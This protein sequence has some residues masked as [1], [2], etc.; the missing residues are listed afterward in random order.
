M[1]TV[2]MLGSLVG[3]A[4]VITWRVR[5]GQTPVTARK[6]LL[7][8]LG[9]STG[10]LMF[11]VPETRVPWAWGLTALLAGALVFAYPLIRMSELR[12]EGERIVLQRSRVFLWILVGLVALR[13]ALRSYVETMVDP[14]QTGALFFVLA[15]G[16]I[17]PWRVA[18]Y[19]RYRALA[20]EGARLG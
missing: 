7:P 18:M 6:I 15:F 2:T 3:A 16:M 5:E 19:L 11:L 9:M 4:V 8:P 14:L 12:R 13:L 10:F 17:V 20:A 1:Q